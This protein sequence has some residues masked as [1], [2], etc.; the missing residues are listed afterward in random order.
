LSF[1][2]LCSRVWI[3]EVEEMTGISAARN[4]KDCDDERTTCKEVFN[5]I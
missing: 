4:E 2:L 5:R 1:L 3:A